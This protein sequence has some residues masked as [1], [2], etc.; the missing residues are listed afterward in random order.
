MALTSEHPSAL[1]R[2]YG[3]LRYSPFLSQL[4]VTRRCN[5][6]CKYCTEFDQV[7]EPVPGDELCRRVDKIASLGSFGLELTGGEPLLHPQLLEVVRHASA[8][9]F[10]MLGMISNGFLLTPELVDELNRA[11]LTDLQISVDGVVPNDMTMKVLKPLRPKLEMLARYAKF[12]VVLSGVVGSGAPFEEVAEVIQ[13]ARDH[14]FRPRVLLIHDQRGQ[15]ALSPEDLKAYRR[16]QK[17]IGW[18]YKD[19]FDYREKLIV[20]GTA[21]FRCRAGS[22]YLY[23]NEQGLVHRCAQ[24]VRDFGKPLMEYTAEDLRE[25]FYTVKNC[26]ASCTIGCARSCSMVDRWFPQEKRDARRV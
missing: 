23:I 10:R 15:L 14:G 5:L 16:V 9:R 25:Q 13:F 6:S 22:R 11:G 26:T 2:V 20:G 4:V 24:T 12:K 7:S 1:A 21:P 19:M 3:R 18:H 17:L 8:Y